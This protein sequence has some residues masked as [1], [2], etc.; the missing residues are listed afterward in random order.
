MI[1]F[2]SF[3][4]PT[5]GFHSS[6]FHLIFLFCLGFYKPVGVATIAEMINI[7]RLHNTV[8]AVA[9]MNRGLQ[10]AQ[11]YATKRVAFR[12]RLSE[13]PLHSEWLARLACTVRGHL[14]LAFLITVLF[15]EA[16]A[17]LP[18]GP[19]RCGDSKS[20]QSLVRLLIPL[21]KL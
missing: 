19:F 7:T 12:H 8:C 10:L 11:N 3:P 14:L 6:L 16:Q 13:L 1:R 21:G 5:F 18:P 4:L 17:T 15:E 2:G 9:Y 20:A